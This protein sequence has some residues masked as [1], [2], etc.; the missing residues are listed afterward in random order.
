[1]NSAEMAEIISSATERINS[2]F[3]TKQ[4]GYGKPY[5]ALHNFRATALRVYGD[6]SP[7]SMLAVLQVLQDKHLVALV[8]K[9]LRDPEFEERC[10]DVAVYSLIAIGI[11]REAKHRE[12]AK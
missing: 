5:D 11:G 2:M 9:G 3:K 6:D 7:E 10:I 12:D 8:N 1:M 4:V